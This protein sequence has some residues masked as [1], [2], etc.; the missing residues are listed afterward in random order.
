[1]AGISDRYLIGDANY[2]IRES[3]PYV[4]LLTSY[5]CINGLAKKTCDLGRGNHLL[6]KL[7]IIILSKKIKSV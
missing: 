7:Q 3:M 4:K 6:I 1:M 5:V 2:N